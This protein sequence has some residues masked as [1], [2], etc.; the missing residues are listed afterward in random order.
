MYHVLITRTAL[1]Y[2]DTL[3]EKSQGLIKRKLETLKETP[4][5]GRDD[6]KRLH[7]P[8]YDLFRMHVS[9]SYT[10]FYRIN[11]EEKTVKILDIMT[12]K[13]AHKRYGRL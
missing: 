4:R 7:F 1:N 10:V 6:K 8:S 3:T 12:I 13:E 2:L 9:R 11:E 5:P